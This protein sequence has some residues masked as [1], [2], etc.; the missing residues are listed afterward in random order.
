MECTIKW[1]ILTKAEWIKLYKTIKGCTLLQSHTY[2]RTL[3]ILG[4]YNDLYGVIEINGQRAGI[5]VA[6]EKK[7]LNGILHVISV[8]RGPLWFEGFGSNQHFAAFINEYNRQFP[9]RLGRKRRLIPEISANPLVEQV[10]K[11]AGFVKTGKPSYQTVVMDLQKPLKELEAG[12][13]KSWRQSLTKARKAGFE[14]EWD[15]SGAKLPWILKHYQLDRQKRG[16][17]GPDIPVLKALSEAFA[18][19]NNLLI[20]IANLDNRPC[21]AILIYMHG[22][23]A[24]YQIGWSMENGRK[25]CAHHILLWEALAQ[26]KAGEINYFDLGGVNDESARGVKTFKTGM[27]GKLVELAGLYI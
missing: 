23:G 6:L 25:H 10:I 18:K 5:V 2:A 13:R 1:N 14:I 26:L 9:K 20:G 22:R 27:G 3:S 24:T 21:A 19:E 4:N 7:A 16:Y 15:K 17:D 12:I 11:E 8:D